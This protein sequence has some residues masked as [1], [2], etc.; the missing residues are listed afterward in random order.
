MLRSS[1]FEDGNRWGH[2]M[3]D[4]DQFRNHRDASD[5]RAGAIWKMSE[6]LEIQSIVGDDRAETLLRSYILHL[7]SASAS[8]RA[9]DFDSAR[10]GEMLHDLKSISGQ[11]GFGA[12]QTFCDKALATGKKAPIRDL[13]QPL[14][15]LIEVSREAAQAFYL[16]PRPI[17]RAAEHSRVA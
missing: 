7:G 2:C 3:I 17:A 8:V 4:R 6:F 14:L 1:S 12:L 9:R 15:D 11:L 10:L 16:R 13:I 5:F